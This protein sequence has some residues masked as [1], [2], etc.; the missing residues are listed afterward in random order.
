M[1]VG[2][3]SP[4]VVYPLRASQDAPEGKINTHCYRFCFHIFKC[5]LSFLHSK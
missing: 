4:D 3:L 1:N 2:A 5:G